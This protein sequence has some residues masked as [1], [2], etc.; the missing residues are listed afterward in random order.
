MSSLYFQICSGFYL[1]LL[2]IVFYSKKRVSSAEN[3]IFSALIITNIFGLILDVVSTYIAIVNVEFFLLNFICKLYLLYLLVWTTI[4]TY[5]IVI[6]SCFHTE[7]TYKS[8]QKKVHFYLSL[9]LMFFTVLT[10]F[11]PLYN[12]SENGVVYTYGPSANTVYLYTGISILIWAVTII[13]NYKYLQLKKYIPA[14][15]FVISIVIA[16]L[17]QNIHPELL[18]VTSVAIFVTF[19]MY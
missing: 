13:K 4:F 9:F 6:I 14:A 12:F 10:I 11:L 5:Y 18:I 16:A 3:R 15:T 19:L 7:D 17:I 2:T 1:L 8:N